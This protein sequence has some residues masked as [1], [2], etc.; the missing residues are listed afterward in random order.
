MSISQTQVNEEVIDI[1]IFTLCRLD[2]ISTF[3]G[4]LDCRFSSHS[5]AHQKVALLSGT[6]HDM[7][8]CDVH[9]V[10]SVLVAEI[11][12]VCGRRT[13]QNLSWDHP[14]VGC[15]FLF[16]L[17]ALSHG[18]QPPYL[19][20]RKNKVPFPVKKC[21]YMTWMWLLRRSLWHVLVVCNSVFGGT[22]EGEGS[23]VSAHSPAV[24]V[25][26]SNH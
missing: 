16:G 20:W 19:G 26:L 8:A 5:M 14:S 23:V 2:S 18:I 15:G 25:I 6:G 12:T 17:C 3:G 10:Q 21:T 13:Y 24:I 11:C 1:L 4:P 7:W 9:A 22:R